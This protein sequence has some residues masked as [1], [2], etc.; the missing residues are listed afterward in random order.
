MKT[1]FRAY[2]CKRTKQLITGMLAISG[3]VFL[4]TGCGNNSSVQ[5]EDARHG[6]IRISVDES[7]KPVIDSQ[8]KVYNASFPEANIVAE[9]KPEADCLKDL[10][11]D[12]IRMV[13]VTRGLT[14]EESRG[15]ESKLSYE[16]PFGLLAFDGVALI[17]NKEAKDSVFT[18][19]D[20][21]QM[22]IGNTAYKY[23]IVMDGVN[24]TSTVRYAIDSLLKGQPIGK[25]VEAAKSSPEVI[26]YVSKNPNSIGMIGVS[27][28]GNQDDSAQLSFQTKIKIASVRCD[29]CPGEPYTKPYQANLA[30]GRYPMRRGLYYI[31]KENFP[32]LGT[33]FMNFMV[34]E[35][36]QLIFKRAY[37]LPA[38]MSFDVRQASI[39]E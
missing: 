17:L 29:L 10:S 12:S 22:L 39:S 34:F 21:R 23:K 3:L 28:I 13:I 35:R 31:L 15:F 30:T 4:I 14:T 27:W 36:G 11:N 2:H 38:R 33:G 6:N 20:I 25:T 8:I 7:F 37:L 18:V 9:Y 24:A 16:P 26:D 5:Q 19:E 32:G 1:T